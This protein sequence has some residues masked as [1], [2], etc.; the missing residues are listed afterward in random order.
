[1][2]TKGTR[3]QVLETVIVMM[4]YVIDLLAKYVEHSLR[5]PLDDALRHLKEAQACVRDHLEEVYPD[6][7]AKAQAG[8]DVSMKELDELEAERR[9]AEQA[10]ERD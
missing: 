8:L 2:P 5:A 6:V 4:T 3:Q 1:M 10:M 9:I 7:V